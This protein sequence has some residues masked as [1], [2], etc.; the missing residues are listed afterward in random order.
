LTT[1][2]Q[3]NGLRHLTRE[4][5][6]SFD[7]RTAVPR[8]AEFRWRALP[9]ALPHGNGDPG[10][11]SS[12]KPTRRARSL[13]V[14]GGNEGVGS[15]TLSLNLAI[16][17]AKYGRRVVLFDTNRRAKLNGPWE[18]ECRYD[19]SPLLTDEQTLAEILAPG[20]AGIRLL[21][22]AG[23]PDDCGRAEPEAQAAI[24]GELERL[25]EDADDLVV[26]LG[27]PWSR[28]TSELL[29]AADLPLL[30]TTPEP[31]AIT[32]AYSLVK[33]LRGAAHRLDWRL[34]VNQSSSPAE[35]HDV[36]DR[37]GGAS[38]RFL[39]T[40]VSG[41]GYVLTDPH[42]PAAARRRRPL[43]LEYPACPASR[44][45]SRIAAWLAG[46]SR[47]ESDPTRNRTSLLLSFFGPLAKCRRGA[48]VV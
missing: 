20:P 21:S 48:T 15:S 14:A 3:A 2:D 39:A 11:G 47:P 37:I 16:A 19:L 7:A 8:R 43:L 30:V 9:A 12:G 34:V 40:P 32:R 45:I 36:L 33:S 41:A 35:A 42:V 10:D 23:T 6:A 26:D 5:G 17:L 44:S 31:V 29:L 27:S 4:A 22:G 18:A 38:R 24:L 28:S 25:E 13:V 46:E 1:Y